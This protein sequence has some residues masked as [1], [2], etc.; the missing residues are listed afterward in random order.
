MKNPYEGAAKAAFDEFKSGWSAQDWDTVPQKCR[1]NWI[2]IAKAA[3]DQPTK[4]ELGLTAFKKAT[5]AFCGL[6]LLFIGGCET[7]SD[8]SA[9]HRFWGYMGMLILGFVL[10]TSFGWSLRDDASRKVDV[11][12]NLWR[13][14]RARR[15]R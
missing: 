13:A 14:R 1:D 4:S 7:A 5:M 3:I 15:G 2:L 12:R 8:G 11:M 10:G 9:P 6:P